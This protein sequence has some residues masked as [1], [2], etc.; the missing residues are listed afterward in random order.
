MGYFVFCYSVYFSYFKVKYVE[1]NETIL[2][3]DYSVKE[4]H[5]NVCAPNELTALEEVGR[6][7][8]GK[9]NLEIKLEKQL[10][11]HC[12]IQVVRWGLGAN[13]A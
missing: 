3:D 12:A 6:V 1:Q 7:F 8:H 4:A 2:E 5:Y 13:E 10:P 11:V 9:K